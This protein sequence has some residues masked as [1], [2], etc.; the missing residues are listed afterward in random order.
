MSVRLIY[1]ESV[2]KLGPRP[3]E[4]QRIDLGPGE[5]SPLNE[6]EDAEVQYHSVQAK[7][8]CVLKEVKGTRGI[9]YWGVV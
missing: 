3:T 9:Y 8:A 7:Y 2:L 4:E 1:F 6:D 5:D